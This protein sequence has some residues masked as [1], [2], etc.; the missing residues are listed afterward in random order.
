VTAIQAPTGIGTHAP[1]DI[2]TLAGTST[3]GWE[4][5]PLE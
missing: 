4:D 1:N 2:S 5:T 3:T